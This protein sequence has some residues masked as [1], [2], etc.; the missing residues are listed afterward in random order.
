MEDTEERETF[1]E[2]FAVSSVSR[3]LPSLSRLPVFWRFFFLPFP[4]FFFVSRVFR[5]FPVFPVFRVFRVF[6]SIRPS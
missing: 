1:H 4:D 6:Y 2:P 5:V 3:V